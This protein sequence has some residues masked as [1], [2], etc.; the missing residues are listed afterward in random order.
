MAVTQLPPGTVYLG[1]EKTD[2][3]DIAA[4]ETITPGDLV[5]RFNNAGTIRFRKQA[6][7]SIR[8]P[9]AIAK[10]ASM[11]GRSWN[12]TYAVNDLMETFIA[13]PGCTFMGWIASGQNLVAG[14]KV[15][16]DGSGGFKVYATLGAAL[17]TCL[18]NTGAVTVRT[19][20]RLEAM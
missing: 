4:S 16:A 13:L 8:T 15:E 6:T 7:A 10:E 14:N 1:G 19:R 9:V 2:V 18:E 11:L 20:V 17:A 5:D 3:C 12:D